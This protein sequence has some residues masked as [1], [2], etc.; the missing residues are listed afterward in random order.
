[1]KETID[2]RIYINEYI[3]SLNRKEITKTSYKKILLKF[4]EYCFNHSIYKP[5]KRDILGYKEYLSRSVR[6]A[7]IQ[8]T[9]VVLRGF[10]TYLDSEGV[11][12]NIMSGIRGV[13]I[14]QTFKRNAFTVEEVVRLLHKAKELATNIEGKRNYAITALLAT[15]GLRTIEVERANVADLVEV[16]NEYKLYIQGKGHDDK[17]QYVK[18]SEEVHDILMDYLMNRKYENDAL[19]LNHDRTHYGKRV[20]TRTIRR[21]VKELLRRIGIDDKRYT[22]HSLRHSMATNLIKHGRSLEEAKQI[23]RHKDISTTQLYN[24]SLKRSENNGELIMSELLF[25]RKDQQD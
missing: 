5:E 3:E 7:S 14:E 17:D 4:E 8:K 9:I 22:T 18:L 23:L 25:K 2:F 20:T 12:P 19:F 6:S 13:K 10:F 16:N 11:Y 21:V 15:T 24:H 1:M